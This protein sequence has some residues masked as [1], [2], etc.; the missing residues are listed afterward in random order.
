MMLLLIFAL[1]RLLSGGTKYTN[2]RAMPETLCIFLVELHMAFTCGQLLRSRFTTSLASM[3]RI[4]IAVSTG[5]RVASRGRRRIRS[6]RRGMR[7]LHRFG[8]FKARSSISGV[9]VR[10]RR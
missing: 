8:N 6:S 5:N 7:A 2:C 1:A 10:T 4:S 3:I 9:L